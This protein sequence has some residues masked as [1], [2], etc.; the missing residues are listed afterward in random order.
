MEASLLRLA[1]I[2]VPLLSASAAAQTPGFWL[3]GLPPGSLGGSVQG[4]SQN[5]SVAVG[6]TGTGAVTPGFS[7][8]AAGGRYDFGLEPGMPAHTFASKA[9]SGGETIVGWMMGAGIPQQRAY[10]RVGNGPLQ[11]LGVPPGET[12]SYASGVSGDGGIVV[13]TA[14]HTQGPVALGQA[15]RWTEGGGMVGLG[16]LHPDSLRS[17]ARAISRDGS[18]IVGNSVSGTLAVEAFRWTAAAGMQG[19]PGFTGATGSV[20]ANAVSANGAVVVG[21]AATA[22]PKGHSHAVRWTGG[23]IEDLGTLVALIS[24][25]TAVSDDGNVVG[26][27]SGQEAFVWTPAT[28][29]LNATDYFSIHGVAVPAG[30]QLHELNAISGDGLTFGGLAFNLTTGLP[31]GFVATIPS[32][33]TVMVLPLLCTRRRRT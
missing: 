29:M 32:P 11:D 27:N 30:Y 23:G 28:G 25:A 22:T 5:G 2:T 9:S 3:T 6:A 13:G 1:L 31:E 21:R 26:G 12:R 19:L 10:R 16:H 17:E 14:E 33:A 15:F 4:L 7:W 8:T 24:Q 20:V 18:T